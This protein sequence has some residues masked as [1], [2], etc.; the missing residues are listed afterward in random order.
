MEQ[1][2]VKTNAAN[3]GA[4]GHGPTGK[5]HDGIGHL[6]LWIHPF[7]RFHRIPVFKRVWVYL[8]LTA[9]YTLLVHWLM[10][11]HFASQAIREASSV[12]Y[13]SVILGLLLVFRTNSAYER[14]SEGRRL[15]GQLV[16][17]TRSLSMKV[18][19]FV[20][21]P[22]RE[23]QEVGELLVSFAFSLK[24]HLRNSRHSH[25]LPGVEPL[26][27]LAGKNIPVHIADKIYSKIAAWKT[28]GFV[29]GLGALQLD[30]HLRALNDILGSCE[31]IRST[32]LA[33][34][35]RAFM[36]QGIAI[37]L[38]LVPFYIS[39]GLE[40]WWKLPI[41]ILAAYF[42]IGLEMIAEDIEDPFGKDG[43]DLPLDMI[44]ANIEKTV[45]QILPEPPEGLDKSKKRF[46]A[47]FSLKPV[48]LLKGDH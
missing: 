22:I 11:I 31:R 42:L 7:T 26:S 46:T 41:V 39:S 15:W 14:W 28:A 37:N 44:C 8:A 48:D 9:I 5:D 24:H 2:E 20:Q 12:G 3:P 25:D 6:T 10:T 21:V 30:P 38:A 43:D 13:V 19:H 35:Y 45:G 47:T 1:H 18:S 36:R 27:E 29:D 40:I 34:S 32:P 4:P 23:K 17:D 16:N 33:I